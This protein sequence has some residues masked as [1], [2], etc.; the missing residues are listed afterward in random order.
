MSIIII[1]IIIIIVSYAKQETKTKQQN[2]PKEK[3]HAQ[4]LTRD[5]ADNPPTA[6]KIFF[7]ALSQVLY[8][9]G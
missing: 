3:Q 5:F 1:I 9:D 8:A 6:N 2:F 4:L 7:G